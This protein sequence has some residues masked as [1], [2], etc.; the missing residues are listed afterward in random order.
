[1]KRHNAQLSRRN[2]VDCFV[3]A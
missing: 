1:M 2:G 3:R